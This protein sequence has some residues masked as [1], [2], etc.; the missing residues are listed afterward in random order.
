MSRTAAAIVLAEQ[1]LPVPLALPAEPAFAIQRFD[2]DPITAGLPL[3]GEHNRLNASAAS[4]VA[5]LF[6]IDEAHIE[7]AWPGAGHAPMRGE[8]IAADDP[9]RPTVINDAYNAN[10]TSMRAALSVLAEYPAPRIAVLGDMLELGDV[11]KRRT[12]RSRPWR[13]H[14]RALRADRST[15]RGGGGRAGHGRVRGQRPYRMVGRLAAQ[16]AAA[17]GQWTRPC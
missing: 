10:P 15:L 13:R 9:S 5:R 14:R 1:R 17:H 11:T 4:A 3:P 6:G 7:A 2:L 8:V 16:I 12:A